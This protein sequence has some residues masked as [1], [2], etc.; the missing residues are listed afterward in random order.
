MSVDV[1]PR[2]MEEGGTLTQAEIVEKGSKVPDT[3][4]RDWGEDKN[5]MQLEGSS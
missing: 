5:T 1:K 2:Q 3:Y 4:V